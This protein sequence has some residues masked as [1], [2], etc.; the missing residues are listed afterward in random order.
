MILLWSSLAS[1]AHQQSAQTK[2][3]N[4]F[5]IKKCRVEQ[6]DG[7][8][9]DNKELRNKL[10]NCSKVRGKYPQIFI[11]NGKGELTYIGMDDK[12][13]EELDSETF[14]KLFECTM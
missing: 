10:F 13:Q 11:E 8:N 5:K 12:I 9:A 3:N 14:D 1:N 4:T 2:M 6:L 7:A